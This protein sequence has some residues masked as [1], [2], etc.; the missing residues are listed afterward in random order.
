M[1]FTAA[2]VIGP[3]GGPLVRLPP[4]SLDAAPIHWVSEYKYLGLK[5]R[6]NLSTAHIM[7]GKTGASWGSYF[8]L[9]ARTPF[10]AASAV[11]TQTQLRAPPPPL[12]H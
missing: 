12:R 11:G 1:A 4:L 5:L 8:T 7:V 6:H 2:S 9:Y 10:I 3:E